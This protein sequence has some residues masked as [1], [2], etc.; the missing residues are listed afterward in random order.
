MHSWAHLLLVAGSYTVSFSAT[1]GS[2]SETQ[3]LPVTV[4]NMLLAIPSLT[5]SPDPFSPDLN[6]TTT[7]SA[8]FNQPVTSW[9]L[10]LKD[11]A[12]V[13]VRSYSYSG[14]GLTSMSQVWNGKTATGLRVP[15]GTYTYTLTAT[16]APGTNGGSATRSGTVRVQ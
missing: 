15:N 11:S 14:S 10:V 4:L 13:T 5:D 7:I 16:A 12:T 1:D 2:L 8:S 6:Q 9:T 3:R